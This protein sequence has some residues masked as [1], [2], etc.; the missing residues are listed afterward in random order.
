MN[1]GLHRVRRH[2]GRT[3]HLRWLLRNRRRKR[4]F[5]RLFWLQGSLLLLLNLLFDYRRL[6]CLALFA[7]VRLLIWLLGDFARFDITQ[8]LFL[9]RRLLSLQDLCGSHAR[10]FVFFAAISD[11]LLGFRLL[12]SLGLL[13]RWRAVRR[14]VQNRFKKCCRCLWI[15]YRGWLFNDMDIFR[16]SRRLGSS[17]SLGR[18]QLLRWLITTRRLWLLPLIWFRLLLLFLLLLWLWFLLWLLLLRLCLFL[19]FWLVQIHSW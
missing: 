7:L 13:R 5:L 14:P 12:V 15:L 18:G 1:H 19:L 8:S 11:S 10:L 2:K 16:A 6:I 3:R 4:L 17:A 9:G